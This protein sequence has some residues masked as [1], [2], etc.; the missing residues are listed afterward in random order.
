MRDYRHLINKTSSRLNFRGGTEDPPIRD[1]HFYQWTCFQCP[2]CLV[3]GNG[4][5]QT[6]LHLGLCA[7]APGTKTK[8]IPAGLTQQG[9]KNS[10]HTK[11]FDREQRIKWSAWEDQTW[12]ERNGV[13]QQEGRT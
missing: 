13:S 1:V 9:S 3:L 5:G 8:F 7:L 6:G 12:E 11:E 2:A 4:M 10:N